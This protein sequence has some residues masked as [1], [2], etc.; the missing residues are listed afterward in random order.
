MGDD[1]VLEL[2]LSEPLGVDGRELLLGLELIFDDAVHLREGVG[3]G[4]A[5]DTIFDGVWARWVG[6]PVWSG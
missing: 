6:W 4:H 2:D 5:G 1:A 3:L